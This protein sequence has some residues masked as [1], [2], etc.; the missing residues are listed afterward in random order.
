LDKFDNDGNRLVGDNLSVLFGF[1]NDVSGL[2][3]DQGDF[4]RLMDFVPQV[5]GSETIVES[6][7]ILDMDY[8][9]G[10]ENVDIN[11]ALEVK[12]TPQFQ[13]QALVLHG[14][15]HS[16]DLPISY[17][18]VTLPSN[19]QAGNIVSAVIYR[20]THL[21]ADPDYYWYGDTTNAIRF[22]C[23]I[24][25]QPGET[26]A[27][28]VTRLGTLINTKVASNYNLPPVQVMY[29]PVAN[30]N[31]LSLYYDTI[32]MYYPSDMAAD[33][34]F[35]NLLTVYVVPIISKLP[36]FKEGT[37]QN[38][39]IE[40]SDDDTRITTAQKNAT[41]RIYVPYSTW[42]APAVNGIGWKVFHRPPMM[43]KRWRWVWGGSSIEYLLQ[44]NVSLQDTIDDNFHTK[45]PF[46]KTIS[47]TLDQF[48][49][50][51]IP[52]YEWQKGDR[53][54]IRARQNSAGVFTYDD[55]G[56]DFE[57]QKIDYLQGAAAY[58]QDT[59]GTSDPYIVDNYG[60]KRYDT[61]QAFLV[62]QLLDRS[63]YNLPTASNSTIQ[64]IWEVYRPKAIAQT[65]LVEGF[66]E[67][68]DWHDVINPHTGYQTHE[69][70]AGATNQSQN[71]VTPATGT[72]NFG[73]CY[74]KQRI[75]S[76]A[77]FY[78]EA[79]Q[80]SDYFDSVVI[81]VGRPNVYDPN[82]RRERYFSNLLYGGNKI[83]NTNVNELSKV[84]SSDHVSLR[85]D[86]GTI[87]YGVEVGFT[88]K[89]VQRSK[90]TSFY[91]GREGLQQAS[92]INPELLTA[93]SKVLSV[94][95][96][97]EDDYGTVFGLSGVKY[98]R[99]YYFYDIYRGCIVRDSPNGNHEISSLYDEQGKP[100]GI[101]NLLSDR[102]KA[103]IADGIEN[104]SV[105]STYDNYTGMV[106][107]SFKDS[108]TP[109]L[110]M[111][112]GFHENSNRWIAFY[113]FNP[114][115][116]GFEGDTL[117][118]FDLGKLWICNDSDIHNNFS[119]VQYKSFVKIV[120]NVSGLIMK[121]FKSIFVSANKLFS[122]PNAGDILIPPTGNNPSGMVSL[123]KEGA[124]TAREGKFVADFG[125]NMVTNQ[126]TPEIADLINGE[127]L[128]GESMEINLQNSDTDEVKLFAV[129][130]DSITSK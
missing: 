40:Y 118:Y 129:Q 97:G 81:S 88:L 93:S 109:S 83:E 2:P 57:I 64:V 41:S 14:N 37:W 84:L 124:F 63:H 32:L 7:R 8:V 89:I 112:L 116:Y 111:T 49:T 15:D 75:T 71:L 1:Y 128:R 25:V 121:R 44:M 21:Y 31:T 82:A 56:A 125:Q 35:V 99:N 27:H 12:K 90:Q 10:F 79:M 36:S 94:P 86:F 20:Y 96:V 51:N 6:N 53:V 113:N 13:T 50:L 29:Y 48:P 77:S 102:S 130:V 68:D 103:Y 98:E 61:G 62:I 19:L 30:P 18:D 38:F 107:F 26:T 28:A 87:A 67:C 65:N 34:Y 58:L 126:P 5:S 60:N 4:Y 114:D 108:V 105:V 42:L 85:Q 100:H 122:A 123:L 22:Q 104:I 101:K 119:G 115:I 127:D 69:G 91:V 45:I 73:D 95:I 110:N 11:T 43:A 39:G 9:E 120:S 70:Q 55:I 16:H 17:V 72:F 52:N 33:R 54:R 76:T 78:V 46:N 47:D 66:K 106:F 3:I 74:V 92:A 117:T 80:F 23:D 59:S 24:V